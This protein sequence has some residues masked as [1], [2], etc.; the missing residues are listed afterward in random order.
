M[1]RRARKSVCLFGWF[2][3][4]LL[5]CC[6]IWTN[7]QCHDDKIR[8]SRSEIV[9]ETTS[10]FCGFPVKPVLHERGKRCYRELIWLRF[11][12]PWIVSATRW[13]TRNLCKKS[14]KRTRREPSPVSAG[15]SSGT[16]TTMSRPKVLFLQSMASPG[17]HWLRCT[18][19]TLMHS[20]EAK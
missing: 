13:N 2:E 15:R 1:N 11:C 19:R 17:I 4:T 9:D 3:K 20:L 7:N 12:W 14:D 10:R 16:C 6:V 18:F 5:G 8:S